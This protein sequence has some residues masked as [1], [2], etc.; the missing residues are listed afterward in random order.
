METWYLYLLRCENGALYTGIAKNPF[1][2]FDQHIKG[3][4]AR[5]TR[6]NPPLSLVYLEPC[7]G[8][9]PALKREMAVKALPKHKKEQ[10]SLGG[11]GAFWE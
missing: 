3:R 6:V 9:V 7:E 4:G 2:R 5:Y 10:L 8:H 1:R 11:L